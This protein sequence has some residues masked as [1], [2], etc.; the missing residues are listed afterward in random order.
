MGLVLGHS[1]I[2]RTILCR[3]VNHGVLAKINLNII[4]VE[5]IDFN[6]VY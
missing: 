3:F 6:D 5:F 1:I 4:Y 2:K